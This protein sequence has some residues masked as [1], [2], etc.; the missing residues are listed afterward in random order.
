[1]VEL[2]RVKLAD[3]FGAGAETLGR[4]AGAGVELN[5]V[6]LAEGRGAGAEY[7]VRAGGL[8]TGRGAVS[9]YRVLLFDAALPAI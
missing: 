7:T 2:N 5:R 6:K 3:G 9:T 1:M 8:Y 4:G